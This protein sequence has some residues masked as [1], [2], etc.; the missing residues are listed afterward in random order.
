MPKNPVELIYKKNL[1][2]KTYYLIFK[3]E[4][5]FDFTPG[6]FFSIE[7]AEKTYRSYSI[8][9]C[10]SEISNFFDESLPKLEKGCYISFMI[11]T[12][13]GGPASEFFEQVEVGTVLNSVGPSGKF[14]LNESKKDKVFISTGTGLAPFIGMIQQELMVNS[15]TNIY[16]YFGTWQKA[17]DFSNQFF[18]EFA[19]DPRFKAFT[20]VDEANPEDLDD[21]TFGGRVTDVVPNNQPNFMDCE[22]YMCGHPAMVQAMVE[23]LKEKGIEDEAIFMEKFGK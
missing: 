8:V 17:G 1:I 4:V 3:S 22:Y 2:P 7:V 19:T 15:E 21:F 13:P 14:K 23:V 12:K 16:S 5:D 11:S 10:G 20:V 9:N 6:Q 18:T